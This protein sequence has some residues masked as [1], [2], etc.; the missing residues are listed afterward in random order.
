MLK[1]KYPILKCL[2]RGQKGFTLI[3][4]LIVV[5]ILAIIA[6]V[7]IP[8]ISRFMITGQLAAANSEVENV[9]TAALG[10]FGEYGF[11]PADSTV[12]IATQYVTGDLKAVY[13]IDGCGDAAGTCGGGN[14]T[15]GYGWIYDVSSQSWPVS[16]NFTGGAAGL[17]GTHGSWK[18][19]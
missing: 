17:N 13:T 10:Y 5:A 8:N 1:T 18:R 9:K 7:V 11:W 16:I 12:L 3:E 15:D 6:A 14:G 4:L 2:H 19:A